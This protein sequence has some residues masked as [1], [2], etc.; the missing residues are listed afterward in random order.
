MA[1]LG[2]RL[3]KLDRS[4]EALVAASEAVV[5]HRQMA[6]TAQAGHTPELARALNTL[7]IRYAEVGRSDQPVG[8]RSGTGAGSLSGIAARAGLTDP[9]AP[10]L[11]ATSMAV[12]MFRR[13][14]KD[15]ADAYLPDLADGL[16]TYAWVRARRGLE[17]D[18]ALSAAQEAISI[19]E[20]L[21]RQLP[22]VF[23]VKLRSAASTLADLVPTSSAPG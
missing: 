22:D 7:G 4:R 2:D 21:A 5:I 11:A 15:D 23:G 1:N 12:G 18:A 17:A 3:A 19:Y 20:P 6:R 9:D 14:A 8:H 16:R 13:L 10:E